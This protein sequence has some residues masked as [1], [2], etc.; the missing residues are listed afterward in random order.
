MAVKTEEIAYALAGCKKRRY[1]MIT[2]CTQINQM[3][4][5]KTDRK[6][7]YQ[8]VPRNVPGSDTIDNFF[9]F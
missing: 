7:M 3:Y 8:G 4:G 9:S 2:V 1:N 5:A 6:E